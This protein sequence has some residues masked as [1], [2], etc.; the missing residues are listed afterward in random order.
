MHEVDYAVKVVCARHPHCFLDLFCGRDRKV[1]LK[2]V[3]DAQLQIPEHRADKIW[4]VHDGKQEGCVMLEAIL[5]PDRR[6]LRRINLKNAAAQVTLSMPVITV[7]L[8]LQQGNYA[9]FPDSYEDRLGNL[10]NIHRFVKIQLWEHI[11]RIRKGELKELAPFLAL[12]YD[13]PPAEILDIENELIESKEDE[14]ERLE[15]KSIAALIGVRKFA[16]QI[17]KQKLKLEFP[18]IRETTIFTEWF[19]QVRTEAR[20]EG[21]AEGRAEGLAE[22]EIKVLTKLLERK[23]GLLPVELK[24]SLQKLKIEESDALATDLFD[25]QSVDDLKA[26]LRNGR[27]ANGKNGNN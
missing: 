20:T 17:V 13:D 25:F 19:D 22:G 4:R 26:W 14:E 27:R 21:R 10:V 16:E 5:V 7:L 24:E 1:E 6:D 12:L 18:M 11:E 9:T 23:F 2:G 8:Y 15:L 3:E